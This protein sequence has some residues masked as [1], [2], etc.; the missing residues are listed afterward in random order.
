MIPEPK[1]NSSPLVWVIA[2]PSPLHRAFEYLPP[3]AA[4][5][6][7]QPGARVKVPFAGR[8]VIGIFLEER[9]SELPVATAL[10][11]VDTLLDIEV[12]LL[13]PD[14]LQLLRWLSEYYLIPH[15]EALQLGLAT[16][17]RKGRPAW[18]AEADHIA[19]RHGTETIDKIPTRASKQRAA[20]QFIG[21]HTVPIAS[22][23]KAGFSAA[24]ISALIKSGAAKKKRAGP[25]AYLP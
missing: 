1:A 13:G 7:P 25:R 12:S 9:R 14:Q 17:E 24:V 5:M 18:T 4:Q 20:A 21:E 8:G 3:S 6:T 10:K 19:L 15:G 23:T 2:V 16:P 11:S 22:L